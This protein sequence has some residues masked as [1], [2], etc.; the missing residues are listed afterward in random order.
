MPTLSNWVCYSFSLPP[1]FPNSHGASL[2]FQTHTSVCLAPSPSHSTQS[3]IHTSTSNL[4]FLRTRP[5]KFR[6]Y[7]LFLDFPPSAHLYLLLRSPQLPSLFL[8]FLLRSFPLTAREQYIACLL[9]F[10]TLVSFSSSLM[11]EFCEVLVTL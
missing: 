1:S 5:T 11:T 2:Y 9:L 10:A 8:L 7:P 4:G 6:L 3:L